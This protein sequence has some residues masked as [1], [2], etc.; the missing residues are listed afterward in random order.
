MN[1]KYLILIVCIIFFGCTEPEALVCPGNQT[2]DECQVCGGPGPEYMC[3][4]GSYA[5]NASYCPDNS[6]T[7]LGC[8]DPDAL[9]YN[10]SAT[11]ELTCSC[12]YPDSYHV[13]DLNFLKFE[14]FCVSGNS[15]TNTDCSHFYSNNA[16]EFEAGYSNSD[17]ESCIAGDENCYSNCNWIATFIVKKCVPIYFINTSNTDIAIITENTDI[18]E[19]VGATITGENC[20]NIDYLTACENEEG[21]D[22]ENP[23]EYNP[24]WNNF[25]ENPILAHT[26]FER[27]LCDCS[28]PG[29]AGYKIDNCNCDEEIISEECQGLCDCNCYEEIISEE[30]QGL[31]DCKN[32]CSDCTLVSNQSPNEC[33]DLCINNP[34]QCAE[35][36]IYEHE[37]GFPCNSEQPFPC[38]YTVG[39]YNEGAFE[40]AFQV[41]GNYW[42]YDIDNPNARA[43]IIVE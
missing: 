3:E 34:E 16:C 33:E 13:I 43:L 9:N 5:C 35:L 2:M 10:P 41:S 7:S 11:Q 15:Y 42:F 26:T 37:D 40:G 31:C 6:Y 17:G 24:T 39:C 18:P 12:I 23:V 29:L 21:C 14:S 8:M 36:C 20:G 22:W 1:I 4:D 38:T 25:T 27:Y 28:G 32:E 30:C 19:C